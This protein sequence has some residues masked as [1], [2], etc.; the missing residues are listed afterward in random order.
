MP[1]KTNKTKYTG[2][3]S[4]KGIIKRATEVYKMS[5]AKNPAKTGNKNGRFCYRKNSDYKKMEYGF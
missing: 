1:K 3:R 2:D 5:N 4:P